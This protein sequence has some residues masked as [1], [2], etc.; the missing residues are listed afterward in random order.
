M[1][2]YIAYMNMITFIYFHHI[3]TCPKVSVAT[4]LTTPQPTPAFFIQGACCIE[5]RKRWDK[6]WSPQATLFS[7]FTW[8]NELTVLGSLKC[9]PPLSWLIDWL[10]DSA[11]TI[12]FIIKRFDEWIVHK[13]QTLNITEYSVVQLG[14]DNQILSWYSAA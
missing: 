12:L 4:L 3:T 13:L 14:Q 11:L 9:D 7:W 1:C 2:I 6:Y 5:R 10:I 8:E